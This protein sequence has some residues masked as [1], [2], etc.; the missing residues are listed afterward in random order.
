PWY[1]YLLLIPLYEQIGLVFGLVGVVRCLL[2]PTRFRLFLIYWTVGNLF[3]YSWASEK[4]PW[5]VIHITMPLMLLA[6]VG[7]EPVV[8]SIADFA[9]IWLAKRKAERQI[10]AKSA[11]GDGNAAFRPELPSDLRIAGTVVGFILA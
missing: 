11:N 9:K 8:V 3:I 5:L 1:Y 6:A 7:L 4:M 10:L 2:R